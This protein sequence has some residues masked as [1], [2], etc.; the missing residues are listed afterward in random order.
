[1]AHQRSFRRNCEL[2]RRE[3]ANSRS[4]AGAR[5]APVRGWRA[6]GPSPSQRPSRRDN[7]NTGKN[8]QSEVMADKVPLSPLEY[9]GIQPGA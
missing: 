4:R 1:M 7:H 6:L 8:W 9:I 5:R 2:I 3:M